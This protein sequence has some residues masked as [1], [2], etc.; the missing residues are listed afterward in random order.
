MKNHLGET[1]E[2]RIEKYHLELSEIEIKLFNS[3]WLDI[4]I[5]IHNKERAFS[6]LSCKSPWRQIG[7]NQTS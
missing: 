4:E 5:S 6:C 3:D 2:L 1:F 7:Q